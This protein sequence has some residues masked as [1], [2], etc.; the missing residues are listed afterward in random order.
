MELFLQ[1][2]AA[3]LLAMILCLMLS[4]QGKETGILLSL[5]VCCMICVIALRY[6]EPV[7]DFLN[8]LEDLGGLDS[9]MV[10]ILLKAAG[11]GFLSEIASLVC[12]DAGNSSLGKS[13]QILGSAVILW[14]S[15]PLFR[16]LLELIQQILGEV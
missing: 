1:A 8:Q 7:M 10:T 9:N 11:I 14:L 6:L 4:K 2:S 13:L 15:I 16:G 12:A 3:A 5:A